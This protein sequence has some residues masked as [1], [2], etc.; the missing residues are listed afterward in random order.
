MKLISFTVEKYRSITNA[1][2]IGLNKIT[3][4]IGPNNEGKSNILL[5]LVAAMNVLTRGGR[6]M[7]KNGIPMTVFSSYSFFDWA[8]DFTINLQE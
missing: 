8:T 2:K 5:S 6:R 4:L 1:R 7:I 3:T